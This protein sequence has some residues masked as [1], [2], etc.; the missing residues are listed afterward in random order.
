MNLERYKRQYQIKNLDINDQKTLLNS[1]IT[2]IGIGALG[3]NISELLTRAGIGQLN[4]IDFDKIEL[5]NLQRQTLFKEKDI[6]KLKNQIAKNELKKI[7]SEII[8]KSYNKKIENITDLNKFKNTDL[9]IDCTDNLKT[10]HIINEFCYT[11]KI[12]WIFNAVSDIEGIIKLNNFK[13]NCFNCV[14]DKK[15]SN[16]NANKNGILSSTIT[17]T[18]SITFTKT[19]K[20]L[21]QKEKIPNEDLIKI[22]SWNQTIEHIKIKKNKKCQICSK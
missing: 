17:L 14:F 4:L 22:D 9:I 1:N 20:Y 18:T 16:N 11:N 10:R 8:I 12:S 3:T 6:N 21:T 7:N 13:T 2:I 15:Y 19:I 5:S